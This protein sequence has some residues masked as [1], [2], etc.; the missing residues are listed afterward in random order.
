MILKNISFININ[1]TL[2]T[3]FNFIINIY[4]NLYIYKDVCLRL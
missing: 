2:I 1:K 3:F 4:F